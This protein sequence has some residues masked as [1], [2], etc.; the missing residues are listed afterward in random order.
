MIQPLLAWQIKQ[1]APAFLECPA[2]PLS[3]SLIHL[4]L[5]TPPHPAHNGC[6]TCSR[7]VPRLG[8]GC[9]RRQQPFDHLGVTPRLTAQSLADP[10]R[11]PATGAYKARSRIRNMDTPPMR[12]A[13]SVDARKSS[14]VS[15]AH[16]RAHGTRSDRTVTT[17]HS[18]GRPQRDAR[19]P[20]A[21]VIEGGHRFARWPRAGATQGSTGW[22]GLLWSPRM[23]A[24]GAPPALRARSAAASSHRLSRMPRHRLPPLPIP[25]AG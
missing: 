16:Y 20:D 22:I 13:A 9:R 8:T 10:A 5:A 1:E 21:A 3:K 24:A 23:S 19:L 17:C 15:P 14:I 6:R 18:P 11:R 7:T 25:T 4:R 12:W 2:A